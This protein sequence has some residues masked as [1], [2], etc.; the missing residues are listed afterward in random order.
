MVGL[1][2]KNYF[3]YLINRYQLSSF[4]R[5]CLLV[6]SRFYVLILRFNQCIK[7]FNTGNFS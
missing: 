6:C 4:S 5:Y 2:S 3:A 7:R 1:R